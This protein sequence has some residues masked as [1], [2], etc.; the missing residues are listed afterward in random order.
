MKRA[1][2]L[3]PRILKKNRPGLNRIYA[4]IQKDLDLV[5]RN[6][7]SIARSSV[8]LISEIGR[9]LFQKSG[10]RIRPALVLLCSRVFGGRASERILLASLV[11]L[12][13]T[14]SLIHDD[15][16]DN[17]GT[18]RGKPALH[19]K[20]GPNVTV[21]LGDH[22]YIK[23][24]SLSLRSRLPRVTSVLAEASVRM[25]EGEI[26][27][28][29]SNGDLGLK[30]KDYLDIIGR[31]TA[32]LFSASC[33]L[34]GIL[35]RAGGREERALAAYGMNLGLC[36]Q[37]VDDILD[38]AGDMNLLG[39]PVLGDLAEG[40]ITLPLIYALSGDGAGRDARVRNL[41]RDGRGELR[42]RQE[43]AA[44]VRSRGGLDYARNKAALYCRRSKESLA[45]LPRSSCTE[46]LALLADFVLARDK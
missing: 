22:L 3:D 32:A 36:F 24:I 10:K 40:R 18:R 43:V 13:H 30:E 9:Y 4:G 16:I 44:L 45:L 6:L 46:S 21:L 42:A 35:G 38:Y 1:P 12:V 34:G 23:S 33:R 15:I 5:E 41:I 19:T 2:V 28:Y 7:R 14:S 31:K 11:E 39:K 29:G 8:P 20:W 37:M 25:I 17:A 26:K 27:E